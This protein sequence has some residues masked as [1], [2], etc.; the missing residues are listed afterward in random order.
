MAEATSEEG[1]GAKDKG[2]IATMNNLVPSGE[3]NHWVK[4]SP[5]TLFHAKH[6]LPTALPL[7]NQMG[8]QSR[9]QICT[10]PTSYQ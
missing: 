6:T 7:N 9:I 1:D 8:G 2:T 10:K 5:Y 3:P 4:D